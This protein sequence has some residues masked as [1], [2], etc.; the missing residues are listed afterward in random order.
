MNP[1]PG[2]TPC[3]QRTGDVMRVMSLR[4]VNS[5]LFLNMDPPPIHHQILP[6]HRQ[7]GKKGTFTM[8]LGPLGSQRRTTNIH[9]WKLADGCIGQQRVDVIV[10]K[11][12]M[13]TAA[14]SLGAGPSKTANPSGNNDGD[15]GG[16]N[17]DIS[18]GEETP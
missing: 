16:N 11:L 8:V 12:P 13:L 10:R 15:H 6:A 9:I 1:I 4:C 2:A 17:G 5:P 18:M 7:K 3:K 14:A